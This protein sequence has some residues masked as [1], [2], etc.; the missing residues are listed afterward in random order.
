MT[1]S[2]T[3]TVT[4]AAAVLVAAEGSTKGRNNKEATTKSK[5]ATKSSC[6]ERNRARRMA[7]EAKCANYAAHLQREADRAIASGETPVPMK[8]KYAK[9]LTTGRTNQGKS[10]ETEKA[11]FK[12]M[13]PNTV[14]QGILVK[15]KFDLSNDSKRKT[16]RVMFAIDFIPP[17]GSKETGNSYSKKKS[18]S[19]KNWNEEKLK[20]LPVIIHP[21]EK[22][23]EKLVMQAEDEKDNCNVREETTSSPI[24]LLKNKFK[25]ASLLSFPS[26]KEKGGSNGERAKIQTN[27]S[28]KG[29][30]K[31]LETKSRSLN[32]K[33]CNANQ[34]GHPH[35]PF[36]R[37]WSP[38][39]LQGIPPH[40]VG[41]NRSPFDP[42]VNNRC[43]PPPARYFNRRFYP[44]YPDDVIVQTESSP[45]CQSYWMKPVLLYE[46]CCPQEQEPQAYAG[47]KNRVRPYDDKDITST[48]EGAA[49]R[50]CFGRKSLTAGDACKQGTTL[51]HSSKYDSFGNSIQNSEKGMAVK[52]TTCTSTTVKGCAS[53]NEGTADHQVGN[54]GNPTMSVKVPV[55]SWPKP[56]SPEHADC[57]ET[58][59]LTSVVTPEDHYQ[60]QV[61]TLSSARSGAKDKQTGGTLDCAEE[62][63]E[64]EEVPPF[65]LQNKDLLDIIGHV[66]PS[67][68]AKMPLPASSIW[69]SSD[70][71]DTA[72]LAEVRVLFGSSTLDYYDKSLREND[73][74]MVPELFGRQENQ[75]Y[76]H[77]LVEEFTNLET[78]LL[79]DG[80]DTG[81]ATSISSKNI[82]SRIAAKSGTFQT[83]LRR[84]C[85]YFRLDRDHLEKHVEWYKEC[86]IKEDDSGSKA[87]ADQLGL[88]KADCD[89]FVYV[90]FGATRELAFSQKGCSQS[91]MKHMNV[92][93]PQTNNSAFRSGGNIGVHWQQVDAGAANGGKQKGHISISLCG[94]SLAPVVQTIECT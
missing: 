89:I 13:V 57:M 42:D 58:N 21:K 54:G 75:T 67:S 85:Q 55:P 11:P 73:V 94:R 90:S 47:K 34:Q 72:P 52:S 65:P 78:E 15:G 41:Q 39:W 36:H 31:S 43:Y 56:S 30:A 7:Y 8:E 48:Q 92:Y 77:T 27:G 76:Y 86:S 70:G 29:C 51:N 25:E 61:F 79:C 4:T 69:P 80:R 81:S 35:R 49:K 28:V 93:F 60:R 16:R 84:I 17:T 33:H 2:G 88:M 23:D 50:P 40:S 46:S 74:V 9:Y 26:I 1:D 24:G 19:V 5:P 62:V 14:I 87:D 38:R 3:S 53:L 59:S 68:L 10:P 18:L 22:G 44:S 45:S 37:H 6:H 20:Q 82:A 66:N 63:E 91:K 12:T 64:L 83:I 32:E 71:L